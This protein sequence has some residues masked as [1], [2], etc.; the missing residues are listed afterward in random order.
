MGAVT[1]QDVAVRCG[2]SR[3]T[4]SLVLQDSN[5]LSIETKYRVR[6]ALREMGY[7]YDRRAANLRAQRSSSIGLI[8]TDVA[9][10]AL[11][12]LAMSVEVEASA[13]D[14]AVMI[15]Y[16]R[17]LLGKQEKLLRTMI[18]HRLDGVIL[19]AADG[20]SRRDLEALERANIP[21]VLVT[22][23]IAGLEC[24]YAGPDNFR[25]GEMLAA[26][27]ADAGA[28]SIAFV[29]GSSLVSAREER[30]GGLEAGLAARRVAFAKRQSIESIADRSG[31]IDATSELLERGPLPDAI[32]AYSDTVA[33]G[34]CFELLQR[35]IVPGHDVAI[36]SFDNSP[37]APHREPPLTSV[38]TFMSAVGQEATRLLF[39]RMR[40]PSLEPHISLCSP[41]L[42]V[43]RSSSG[44]HP[45]ATR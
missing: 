33:D 45:I 28:R 44:W 23:R 6:E 16:S 43:R 37:E 4:V 21:Y 3:A 31:G 2:V 13:T 38:D 5:R 14:H 25:A 15:G 18:E 8:L 10:R 29:G 26:H 24:D 35:G 9:N 17:D 42:H 19:S 7:V 11:A 27:L 40:D 1:L 39:E 41:E 36:A 32:V 30:C 12:D 34:V 20:T 22:R